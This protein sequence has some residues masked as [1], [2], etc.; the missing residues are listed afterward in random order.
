LS[1]DQLAL[2]IASFLQT[3]NIRQGRV[4]AGTEADISAWSKQ[5]LIEAL[6]MLLKDKR[7]EIISD[8]SD[9]HMEYIRIHELVLIAA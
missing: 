3:N 4:F 5:D 7:F 6:V 9:K 8:Y 2:S 1:A